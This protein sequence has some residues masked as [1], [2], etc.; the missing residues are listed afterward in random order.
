MDANRFVVKL[1]VPIHSRAELFQYVSNTLMDGEQLD[2]ASLMAEREVNGSVEIAEGIV[3][4]HV[5]SDV[6]DKSQIFIVRPE[7]KMNWDEKIKHVKLVIMIL[8]RKD[9]SDDVKRDIG[10]FTRKLADDAFLEYLMQTDQLE[11]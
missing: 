11:I 2:L 10:Q 3:L 1:D 8:L 7:N 4:P 6:L 5:E 9:E